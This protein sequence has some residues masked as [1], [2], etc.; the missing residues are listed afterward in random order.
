[1]H[2]RIFQVSE[3]PISKDNLINK[4]KYNENFVG[5]IADYVSEVEYESEQIE[6]L[7]WLSK[8]TEGIKVD[9]EKGTITIIS[10]RMYFDEKHDK[11]K[12][13]LEKLQDITL[14][15]FITTDNSFDM[16]ELKKAYENEY[17]FYIDDNNEHFGLIPLDNWVRNAEENKVYY[18]GTI[19][20]YHY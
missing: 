1:M 5:S 16:Y 10:K 7:K 19:I 14:E 20:D 12:S 6:D 17:G 15:E 9:I 4:D 8:A 11:F 13:I 3:E 18:L 2:S